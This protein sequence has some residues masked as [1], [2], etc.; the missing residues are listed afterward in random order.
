MD[1]FKCDIWSLG[2]TFY[3]AINLHLP[4]NATNMFEYKKQTIDRGF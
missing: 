2:V 1:L 4:F 3:E